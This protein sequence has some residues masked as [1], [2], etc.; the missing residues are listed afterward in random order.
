MSAIEEV[1][2]KIDIVEV[3]SQYTKL[4]KAG[5][6]FRGLCPFHSE[7]HASFFVYPDQQSWH[8]FGACNTGGDVLSFVMKKEGFSFGESLN[9]LAQRA[10]INLPSKLAREDEKDEEKK[11]LYQVIEAAAQYFHNSLLNSSAGEKARDYLAKRGFAAKSIEDFQLGFSP[12]S[13]E[14]LRLY[15]LGKGYAESILLAA[16]LIIKT[17]DGRTHDRFR[18]R[19]MFPI[20]DTRGNAIG[21][22]ARA[23]DNSEPKYLNSPQTTVFDKGGGFY[24]LD[25]AAASIRRQDS[26]VIVEGYVDVI[27]AHQYDFRNVIASMGTSVTEK[28]VSILK[29]Y[30]RNLILALDSDA[31]GEEA[32]L[33]GVNYE[34]IVDNEIKVLVLPEGKDPDD[35][36]K[37]DAGSWEELLKK[38]QPVVDYTFGMV[39]SKLD[40]SKARD[41]T[42]AVRQLLPVITGIK[43]PVRQA[44]YLQKLARSIRVSEQTLEAELK[45]MTSLVKRKPRE[46]AQALTHMR[47][48]VANPLEE[49]CLALLLQHPEL[50]AR[51]SE[52]PPEYF[53]NTENR[54]IYVMWR[55]IEDDSL[56]EEK[57]EPAIME[58]FD[59][60][61]K[62][63]LPETDIEER[64]GRYLLRLR[65]KFLKNLEARKAQILAIEAEKGGTSAELARLQEEGID[66]SIQLLDIFK[67]TRGI[68]TK[69]VRK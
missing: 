28:Q 4:T 29:R 48:I 60:L 39:T 13:W 37:D 31:A 12:D 1:K 57:L 36:I 54:E 16:G 15:L 30:T 23:L 8:C 3:V 42:M 43:E 14:A 64:Y 58:H 35:I 22:G 20:R 40:L 21:F 9:F 63:N 56:L 59:S 32:M 25:L 68:G 47:S 7:K 67:Q 17:E 34:S 24:G 5:K 27:I 2:Q 66:N 65:E 33:R 10:G 62:L 55:Q 11:Q 45:S 50:K 19:L 46:T 51:S 18:G 41:K 69:E 38:A 53:Q 52:L 6:V 44:H 49:H 26:A 61:K